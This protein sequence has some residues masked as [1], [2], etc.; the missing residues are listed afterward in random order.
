MCFPIFISNEIRMCFC[1][2]RLYKIVC[3]FLPTMEPTRDVSFIKDDGERTILQDMIKAVDSVG[4]WSAL[5]SKS[6]SQAILAKIRSSMT[7]KH[8]DE[9]FGLLL[10][11]LVHMASNWKDWVEKRRMNQDF[12]TV[13][14]GIFDTWKAK[15]IWTENSNNVLLLAYLENIYALT[16][17]RGL[18]AIQRLQYG[19]EKTIFELEV[20]LARIDLE[21]MVPYK[22]YLDEIG[23]AKGTEETKKTFQQ[24][25]EYKLEICKRLDK[26]HLP[27][28]Y[29]HCKKRWAENKRY[30]EAC[31]EMRA[32]MEKEY[33]AQHEALEL[34]LETKDICDVEKA[35]YKPLVDM[36]RIRATEL[37]KKVAALYEEIRQEDS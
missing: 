18:T 28:N 6:L 16:V 23:L 24:S 25:L 1:L 17:E 10:Q 20:A 3:S 27:I 37:Y 30:I 5:R 26:I 33:K 4:A 7:H 35:L 29:Q 36:S 21:D 19:V 11:L 12:D 8:D 31:E 2:T 32:A 14:K 34:A 9:T 13:N 15:H 22:N